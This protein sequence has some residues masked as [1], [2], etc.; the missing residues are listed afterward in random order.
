MLVKQIELFFI[1]LGDFIFEDHLERL[2][3][4]NTILS[5]LENQKMVTSKFG[6]HYI[7]CVW[8]N[9][10]TEDGPD[11]C[12]CCFITS[13]KIEALRLMLQYF[14]YKERMES[15]KNVKLQVDY[16]T[17]ALKTLAKQ[18]DGFLSYIGDSIFDEHIDRLKYLKSVFIDLSNQKKMTSRFGEHFSSCA[19]SSDV[20][21]AGPETCRCCFISTYKAEALKLM[22]RYY[23]L[24]GRLNFNKNNNEILF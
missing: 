20:A 2:K 7:S 21:E 24:K 4:I 14:S 3:H 18:I 10:D 13:Y 1:Q 17:L 6:E 11:T 8:S 16:E 12:R 22:T 23:N 9:N 15:D 5:E 19:W